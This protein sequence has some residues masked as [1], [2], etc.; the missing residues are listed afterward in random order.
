MP[1]GRPGMKLEISLLVVACAIAVVTDIR[2]RKIPNW[3]TA[4]LAGSAL[5]AHIP[6]G[7]AAVG[8]SLLAAIVFFVLGTVVHSLRILG[9]GDVKLLAAGSLALGYPDCMLFV[10]YTLLGGGVLAAV[11]AVA[12]RRL[13]QTLANV[14][15]F[16]RTRV[17]LADAAPAARMPYA[18]AI[19]FGAASVVLADTIFP[20]VRFLL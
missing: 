14:G 7:W 9:G 20:A 1:A 8:G 19:A 12:Q 18:V 10:L 4:G 3:L 5:L 15:A 17:L 6:Q 16:A 2:T 13:Q 11:I